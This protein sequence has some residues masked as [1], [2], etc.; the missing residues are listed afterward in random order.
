MLSPVETINNYKN[1]MADYISQAIQNVL[2]PK[3][4]SN[5]AGFKYRIR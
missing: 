5:Y 4:G 3:N 2:S 1:E